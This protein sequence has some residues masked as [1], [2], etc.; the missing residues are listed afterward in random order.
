MEPRNNKLA[1]M[2]K[3]EDSGYDPHAAIYDGDGTYAADTGFLAV[4]GR[5]IDGL[6][7]SGLSL[8]VGGH[9]GRCSALI[10]C[11]QQKTS[12]HISAGKTPWNS[13]IGPS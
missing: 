4:E 6:L 5:V 7:K 3:P 12:F 8:R 13:L 10:L 9:A 1:M 2:L 11:L